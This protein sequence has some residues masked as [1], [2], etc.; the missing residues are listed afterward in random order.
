MAGLS[1]QRGETVMTNAGGTFT[2]AQGRTCAVGVGAASHGHHNN[3]PR[4]MVVTGVQVLN[5]NLAI[6]TC[7]RLIAVCQ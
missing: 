3:C 6:L 7:A 5:G 1:V 2:D 4:H